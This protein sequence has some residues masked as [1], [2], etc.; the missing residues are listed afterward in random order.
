MSS[1]TETDKHGNKTHQLPYPPDHPPGDSCHC[2]KC[3]L[4]EKVQ[5]TMFH[6]S[7]TV[8]K[9]SAC[10][11]TILRC[12]LP[13]F[14]DERGLMPIRALSSSAARPIAK[15]QKRCC[16]LRTSA[17]TQKSRKSPTSAGDRQN[18]CTASAAAATNLIEVKD[19]LFPK[20]KDGPCLVRNQRAT[21]SSL[22]IAPRCS[23]LGRFPW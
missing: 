14:W 6:T 17:G 16:G 23:T 13:R 9:V 21:H 11:R 20:A 1:C 18:S 10:M 4:K 12:E 22:R 2:R 8:R 3:T 15:A 5:K 19:S 7:S